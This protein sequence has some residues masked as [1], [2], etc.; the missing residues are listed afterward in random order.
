MV[1]VYGRDG[2][3]SLEEAA[4]A[5]LLLHEEG[6]IREGLRRVGETELDECTGTLNGFS[7][8]GGFGFITPDD[9]SGEDDVFVEV[10][11][12]HNGWAVGDTVTYDR[13]WDRPQNK[14]RATNLKLC[15]IPSLGPIGDI[16]IYI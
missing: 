3:I 8:L 4:K 6:W 11:E 9:G 2:G 16:H 7:D 10:S 13:K 15:P 14:F 12:L 5:A 1:L